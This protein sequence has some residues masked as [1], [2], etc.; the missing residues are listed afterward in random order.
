MPV[1]LREAAPCSDSSDSA[2]RLSRRKCFYINNS[3]PAAVDKRR[4]C[5]LG[6]CL[7]YMVTKM[8]LNRKRRA[9]IVMIMSFFLNL[10]V[11]RVMRTYAI[12]PIPIP[13]EM[14]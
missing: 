11:K 4:R 12:A 2:H 10:P 8:N 5:C 1:K 13:F 7:N 3:I 6:K 9:I 14:E